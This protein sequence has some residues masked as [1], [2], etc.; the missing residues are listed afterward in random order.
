M[1]ATAGWS[2]GCRERASDFRKVRQPTWPSRWR[3]RTSGTEV[4]CGA[5]RGQEVARWPRIES[6]TSL[7]T[8]ASPSLRSCEASTG[9][10]AEAATF[11]NTRAAIGT[12][13]TTPGARATKSSCDS[14]PA[15]SGHRRHINAARQ[16]LSDGGVNQSADGMGSSPA[17]ASC[18]RMSSFCHRGTFRRLM[19]IVESALRRLTIRTR[20]FSSS[21][22]G[23]PR[24]SGATGFLSAAPQQI[25]A[26]ATIATLWWSPGGGVRLYLLLNRDVCD[27]IGRNR[28]RLC[29]SKN[30]DVARHELLYSIAMLATDEG[31]L[32]RSRQRFTPGRQAI[33]EQRTNPISEHQPLEQTVAGEACWHRE[34]P[35]MHTLTDG[36]WSSMLVRPFTSVTSPPETWC[37]AGTTGISP[38]IGQFHAADRTQNVGE[39]AQPHLLVE[40][41]RIKPHMRTVR[42]PFAA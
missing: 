35:C 18:A 29:C 39:S 24:A 26:W 5:F 42:R 10:P 27:A 11:S 34:L 13:A 25:S 40:T 38:V 3:H 12:P 19:L 17:A 7:T 32:C 8:T 9:L 16:I 31:R 30:A 28:H 1:T 37:C 22:S 6:N 41:P 2:C 36:K 33:R 14:C 21:M 23:S 20:Q 15:H 4:Q